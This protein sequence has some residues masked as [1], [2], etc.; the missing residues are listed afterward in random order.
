MTQMYLAA[1]VMTGKM[2]LVIM[3][4]SLVTQLRFIHLLLLAKLFFA[5]DYL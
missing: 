3:Q 1:L 4:S 5:F 2:V